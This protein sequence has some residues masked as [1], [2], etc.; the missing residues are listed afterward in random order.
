MRSNVGRPAPS[1]F[2]ESMTA[3]WRFVGWCCWFDAVLHHNSLVRRNDPTVIL[4][5]HLAVLLYFWCRAAGDSKLG[6]F[7]VELIGLKI[8]VGNFTV[9]KLS[10]IGHFWIE[11]RGGGADHKA[12]AHDGEDRFVHVCSPLEGVNQCREPSEGRSAWLGLESRPICFLTDRGTR[13]AV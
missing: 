1:A 5:H 11:R 3:G 7:H 8:N 10:S 12:Q 9:C 2:K 4:G 6:I 13:H